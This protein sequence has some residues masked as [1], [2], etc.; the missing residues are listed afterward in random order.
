ASYAE[1]G[2]GLWMTELTDGTPI[3]MCGLLKRDSLAFPD[4]GFAFFPEFWGQ[5]FA[6]E[7]AEAS[8]TWGR[9][10]RALT[11]IGAI[12]RADNV[13]SIRVL[14]KLG[15]RFDSVVETTSDGVEVHLYR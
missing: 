15:L 9:E 11:T 13:G 14:E 1:H 2:F 12:A 3:G 7:A 8:M 6:T 4:V 10:T 5:G